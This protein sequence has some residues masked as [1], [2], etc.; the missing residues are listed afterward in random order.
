[1]KQY[2]LSGNDAD[3]ANVLRENR[4]RVERGQIT[5]TPAP[6]VRFLD[7]KT[8]LVEDSKDVEVV[9]CKCQAPEAPAKKRSKKSE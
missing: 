4:V 8:V 2:I 6:N 9:D 3:V 7:D 1:M 5:F